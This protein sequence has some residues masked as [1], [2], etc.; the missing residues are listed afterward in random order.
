[1]I[2]LLGVPT[3]AANASAASDA[4]V[5]TREFE[6]IKAKIEQQLGGLAEVH[7]QVL[8]RTLRAFQRNTQYGD[9]WGETLG[10]IQL[11]VPWNVFVDLPAD[12]R[13]KHEGTA[14]RHVELNQH[15]MF[16]IIDKSTV[17]ARYLVKEASEIPWSEVDNATT[18]RLALEIEGHVVAWVLAHEI[19]HHLADNVD[20]KP[21]SLATSREWELEADKKAFEILNRAGFSLY[22]LSHYMQVMESLERIKLRLGKGN[23]ESL[24]NHPHWSTR[25]R[26]L[27][28][29][30]EA[31]PPVAHR[32]VVYNWFSYAPG[33]IPLTEIMYLLPGNNMEH[34]GFLSV[35]GQIA[36][37]G[38]EKQLNNSAIIY[39]R[40]GS[41][42]YQHRILDLSKHVTSVRISTAD[43]TATDFLCFRGSFAGTAVY[44][45]SGQISDTLAYDA[46]ERI[47]ESLRTANINSAGRLEAERLF[48]KRT[49]ATQDHMLDF[50]RGILTPE[51]LQDRISNTSAFYDSR[52]KSTLGQ[53]QFDRIHQLIIGDMA[54]L[55][56]RR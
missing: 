20:A 10:N 33:Q 15:L 14:G 3:I 29:Y 25:L 16:V 23:P 36:M 35:G 13:A 5:L 11:E 42:V 27:N 30:M 28:H 2:F 39:I 31:N 17:A 26:E 24:S 32:W 8:Y 50:Y 47:R 52:L 43:G 38:V 1:M 12:A 19:A 21:P 45:S 18:K 37:V 40:E 41:S 22:L 44:D 49:E 54:D 46:V 56:Q 9:N 48:T 55:I 51:Q 34:I 4:E 7:R 53:Q 6:T